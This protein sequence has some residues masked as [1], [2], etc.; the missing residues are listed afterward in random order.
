MQLSDLLGAA[1]TDQSGQRLGTVTD[2]RLA[3]HC[4]DSPPSL[5]GLVISPRTRSS[6]LGY[7]RSQVRRPAALSALLRWRHRGT[8]LAMWRDMH[9]ITDDGI[10]LRQGFERYS[11]VLRE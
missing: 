10:V 7:E 2:V 1:V 6:Y 9:A 4:D 8:F 5:F 11:A 3:V